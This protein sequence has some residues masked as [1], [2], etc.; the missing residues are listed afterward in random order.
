MESILSFARAARTWNGREHTNTRVHDFT[1]VFDCS[2]CTV[3]IIYLKGYMCVFLF[4]VVALKISSLGVFILG[5]RGLCLQKSGV[6]GT[7]RGVV[8]YKCPA[9]EGLHDKVFFGR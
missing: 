1:K 6:F 5:V 8:L 4:W 7:W 3:V 2:A 9:L